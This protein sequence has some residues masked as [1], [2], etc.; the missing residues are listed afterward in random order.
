M[1]S[2][3]NTPPTPTSTI[4]IGMLGEDSSP[5]SRATHTADHNMAATAMSS[6]GVEFGDSGYQR[7]LHSAAAAAELGIADLAEGIGMPNSDP[8]T[9]DMSAFQY[10]VGSPPHPPAGVFP[11]STLF[12]DPPL[13]P[14]RMLR[15]STQP[16][17]P[18]NRR[19][20]LSLS[21][22]HPYTPAL[23]PHGK[24]AQQ[25][26]GSSSVQPSTALV[27]H[28]QPATKPQTFI[29]PAINQD[30]SFK[31]C[32]NCMTATTPSWR[33]HPETQALLC[34]ACGLYLRLHRKPRPITV[35][36]SGN[37]QVIR[38]NAAQQQ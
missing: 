30:G 33:R 32:T 31:R 5:A 34:N 17:L 24:T 35:D 1:S 38:K 9:G 36:E 11:A 12:A 8:T 16:E 4:T 21:R 7:Y 2:P 37:V 27:L 6:A 29:I 22:S 23:D 18:P 15:R 14:I 3:T 19:G 28:K 26:G 20:S 10:L 25:R 13:D